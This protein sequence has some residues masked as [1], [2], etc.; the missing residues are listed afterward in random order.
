V[1]EILE[2]ESNRDRESAK[3]NTVD[4]KCK[5]EGGR[6][7]I[8]EIQNQREVDYLQ[9]LLWGTSKAVVESIELGEGYA[10][11]VKVISISILYYQFRGDE[12]ENTDFIYYGTTELRGFYTQ[13]PLI[14]HHAI[15]QG[16]KRTVLTSNEVFPEYYLIYADKFQ[17]QINHA[18][19]EWVYFFKHGE[20]RD[21][22]TSPGIQLAAKKLDVLQMPQEQRK[23][24]ES[25]MAYLS[26]ERSIIETAKDEGI[27]EGIELG[28]EKGIGIGIEKGNIQTK[29][30]I[31]LNMLMNDVDIDTVI[32]CT[33][34][35]KE[36]IEA[37][38]KG[39]Q[40]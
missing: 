7:I 11:V 18:I 36:E 2:S 6:I 25:Y 32:K 1:L 20:I 8:I 21:D 33:G 16:E 10:D 15:V 19:D 35:T 34:L 9:R 37:I 26:R 23:S 38:R 22:F 12:K 3:F 24:Y 28:I 17:N 31:A 4:L 40:A 5:D 27:E 29:K 30:Q 13:K 39:G 14:L